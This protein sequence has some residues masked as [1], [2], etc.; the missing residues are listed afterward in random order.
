[1]SL[2]CVVS[3]T[4]VW[5]DALMSLMTMFRVHIGWS[6]GLRRCWRLSE[7]ELIWHCCTYSRVRRYVSGAI[8]LW[9][10]DRHWISDRCMATGC[11]WFWCWVPAWFPRRWCGGWWCLCCCDWWWLC[12]C[13]CRRA[14]WACCCLRCCNASAF[15]GCSC[16]FD[17]LLNAVRSGTLPWCCGW[18]WECVCCCMFLQLM[19]FIFRSWSF[20][21]CKGCTVG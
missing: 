13:C 14:I 3:R 20:L 5:S 21:T 12:C 18:D 9:L 8:E 15:I 2:R 1:M 11:W 19:W 17:W 16:R 4:S 10:T 7:L 6:S